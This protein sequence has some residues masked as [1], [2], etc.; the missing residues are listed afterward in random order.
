ML[1]GTIG[2]TN[3]ASPPRITVQAVEYFVIYRSCLVVW[4]GRGACVGGMGGGAWGDEGASGLEADLG[5]CFK[6]GL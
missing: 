5:V 6:L 3:A 4:F 2:T 1:T